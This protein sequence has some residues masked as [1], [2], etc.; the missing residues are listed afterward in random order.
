MV[1]K[2][3]RKFQCDGFRMSLK[4]SVELSNRL[5]ATPYKSA[6]S[7]LSF[8]INRAGS[9]LTQERKKVLNDAK[10]WLRIIFKK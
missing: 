4:K 10:I 7:M 5:R 2:S 3:Y 6:M 8:Y 9:N 1:K